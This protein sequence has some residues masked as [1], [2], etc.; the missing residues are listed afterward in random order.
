VS[1]YTSVNVHIFTASGN[2]ANITN[3]IRYPDIFNLFSGVSVA[4]FAQL[5]QAIS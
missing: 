2:G 4:H 3:V 1:T 5:Q